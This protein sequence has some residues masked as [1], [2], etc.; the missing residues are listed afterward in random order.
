MVPIL[1]GDPDPQ[2]TR[3]RAVARHFW[4]EPVIGLT[5]VR[6]KRP[7]LHMLQVAILTLS[8]LVVG[9]GLELVVG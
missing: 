7:K 4:S 9:L 6:L 3:K 1:R 5:I 8:L 2:R